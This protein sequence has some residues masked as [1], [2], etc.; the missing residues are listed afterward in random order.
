MVLAAIERDRKHTII[1]LDR[2][3]TETWG[4]S[5]HNDLAP[6]VLLTR[7]PDTNV[8]TVYPLIQNNR[9]EA[10]FWAAYVVGDS[11][12]DIGVHGYPETGQLNLWIS[13]KA[14]KGVSHKEVMPDEVDS[15]KTFFDVRLDGSAFE[16]ER[17]ETV[18]DTIYKDKELLDFE[19]ANLSL[20]KVTRL[21]DVYTGT[22]KNL[23]LLSFI[24]KRKH[25]YDYDER[26]MIAKWLIQ[27]VDSGTVLP[28][29]VQTEATS[30]DKLPAGGISSG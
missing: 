29:I 13:N 1:E 8:V 24:P 11:P 5:S 2:F 18:F 16:G 28:G 26:V 20:G 30:E 27:K 12:D 7:D 23:Y 17:E 21:E 14:L 10:N 19:R 6:M 4:I 22:E 25:E 9:R 3:L 15:A